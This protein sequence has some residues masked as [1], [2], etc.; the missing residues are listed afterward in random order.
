MCIFFLSIIIITLSVQI[1]ILPLAYQTPFTLVYILP[2]AFSGYNIL[3]LSDISQRIHQIPY[4][5]MFKLFAVFVAISDAAVIVLIL[6]FHYLLRVHVFKR[7]GEV[8]SM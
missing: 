5:L 4:S 3:T 1:C 6:I 8:D 2:C 7:S